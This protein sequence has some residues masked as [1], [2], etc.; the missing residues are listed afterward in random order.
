M[1][2]EIKL[3]EPQ[4]RVM[5]W[6]S[7]GWP[8]TIYGRNGIAINGKHVCNIDTITALINAG[9]VEADGKW[10]WKATVAGRAWTPKNSGD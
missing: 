4:K 3:T 8:A 1:T 6:M 5:E 7:K 9:L 10:Q 2:K